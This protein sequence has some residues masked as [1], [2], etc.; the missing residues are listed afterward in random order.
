MPALLGC[1]SRSSDF[2]SLPRGQRGSSA[3]IHRLQASSN[4]NSKNEFGLSTNQ[5]STNNVTFDPKTSPTKQSKPNGRFRDRTRSTGT[6]ASILDRNDSTNTTLNGIRHSIDGSRPSLVKKSKS[7][8]SNH[9]STSILGRRNS[10][11]AQRAPPVSST[12]YP[13]VSSDLDLDSNNERENPFKRNQ[14]DGFGEN[15]GRDSPI[16]FQ[17]G[18]ISAPSSPKKSSQSK[19]NGQSPRITS[20]VSGAARKRVISKDMIGLPTNFQV[21]LGKRKSLRD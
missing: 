12:N 6:S 14:N 9:S 2:D 21:S 15:G 5:S 16:G 10:T 8:S 1:T 20:P 3:A 11:L 17:R 13:L 19:L 18:S 4:N 7:T